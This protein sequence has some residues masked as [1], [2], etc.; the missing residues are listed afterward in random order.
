MG[1]LRGRSLTTMK[2]ILAILLQ[3]LCAAVA[4]AVLP[5]PVTL[6]VSVNTN[7]VVVAPTNFWSTNGAAIRAVVTGGDPA[8]NHTFSTNAFVVEGSAVRLGDWITLTNN[9]T[10]DA[11]LLRDVEF[12]DVA[13]LTLDATD[14][15]LSGVATVYVDGGTTTIRGSTNVQIITP[16]ISGDTVTNGFALRV[17]DAVEGTVEYSPAESLTFATGTTLQVVMLRAWAASGAY[18]LTSATRDG[19]GVVTTATVSWPDGSSGAYVTVSKN[20]T[21]LTVDAYT[22]THANSGKTATQPLVTRD[23]NGNVTAQPAITITP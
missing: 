12:N 3:L 16:G 9:L 7:G 6:T 13:R 5:T 11:D 21:W 2:R 1:D 20:P 19:D 4:V 8:T 17:I 18:T 15:S 10:F 22:V 23:G 14:A